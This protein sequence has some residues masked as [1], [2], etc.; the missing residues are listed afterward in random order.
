MALTAVALLIS[1]LLRPLLE[2]HF[3]PLFLI[4]VL[5]SAWFYGLRGGVLA[6][7]LC[8]ATLLYFFLPPRVFVH[9]SI[10]CRQPCN[11]CCSSPPRC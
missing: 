10:V 4:A 9:D 8:G 1:V 11:C 6:T 7:V 2:P 5:F 3:F